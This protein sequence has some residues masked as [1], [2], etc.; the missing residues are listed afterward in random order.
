[1][2]DEVGLQITYVY[3]IASDKS[4]Q[5]KEKEREREREKA[6]DKETEK[7]ERQREGEMF[8]HLMSST[9]N[10]CQRH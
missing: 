7:R 2:A 1:M 4:K 10:F 9:Q 6:K 3:Q 5:Q 8:F